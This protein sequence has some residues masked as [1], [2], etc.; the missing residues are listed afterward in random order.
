MEMEEKDNDS[1][2]VEGFVGN[3]LLTTWIGT[4]ETAPGLRK[5]VENKE[6]ILLYEPEKGTARWGAG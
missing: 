6:K 5:T 1:K 2:N 3:K 4:G